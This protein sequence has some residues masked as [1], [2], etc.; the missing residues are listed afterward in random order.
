MG[1]HYAREKAQFDRMWDKLRKEYKA[2]GME[3]AAIQELYDFDWRWFCS[4]RTYRNHT[5]QLPETVI[6]EDTR[7]ENS[8]LFQRF[9]SLSV[10]PESEMLYD[11][12]SWV[13]T[14]SDIRLI[15]TLKRLSEKDIELLTLLV[16]EG[17]N[18][19]EVAQKWGCSQ[20]AVSKQFQKIKKYFK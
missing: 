9:A 12:Y 4:Q 18:Q 10:L 8:R 14:L 5:Q 3:D 7:G 13:D 1:F 19:S 11:R 15:V 17:F 20:R 16:I 6:R 2:A